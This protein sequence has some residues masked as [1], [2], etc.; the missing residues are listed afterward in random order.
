MATA[1]STPWKLGVAP[2]R[3]PWISHAIQMLRQPLEFLTSMRGAGDIVKVRLGLEWVYLVQHPEL[4]R[5]VLVTDLDTFDKGGPFIEKVRVI[6]GNGL[7][8]CPHEEHRRQRRLMQPLFNPDRLVSYATV[9]RDEAR[10][11]ADSWRS[12]Q[13]VEVNDEMVSL[14]LSIATRTMFTTAAAAEA[15]AEVQDALSIIMAGLYQRMVVPIE[16]VQRLPTRSNRQFDGALKRM[17]TLVNQITDTYRAAGVDHGDLLSAVL[18]ARDDD[19]TAG[20]TNSEIHDQIMSLLIGGTETTA[21]ALTWAFHVLGQ[22]PE[23]ERRL[24]AE[25]DEVLAGRPAGF[26]D[27]AKLDYTQRV[28]TETLRLYPPGWIFTRRTTTEVEL[29]G[30]R[31]APGTTILFSPYLQHRDPDSFPDPERFDPERWLPDRAKAVP[32]CAMIP[33]GVGKRRCIGE[34]F[35]MNEAIIILAT[36][37]GRWRLRPTASMKIRRIPRMTLRPEA[38]PMRVESRHRDGIAAWAAPLS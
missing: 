1:P 3:L 6:V 33:F 13:V 17:R 28:I 12:G 16:L 29:G 23:I 31:L 4:L 35:S 19:T 38:L 11:K 8:T 22:Y 24:H 27:L 26:D 18:A 15:I 25:V 14:S 2:G 36:L 34:A 20:P 10:A 37:A 9:M 21:I 30:H 7:A 5:Q 32:R